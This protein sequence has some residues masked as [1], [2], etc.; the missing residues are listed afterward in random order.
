MKTCWLVFKKDEGNRED[1]STLYCDIVMAEDGKEAIDLIS[2]KNQIAPKRLYAIKKRIH[3]K[4][5]CLST[6]QS[7]SC[8]EESESGDGE[9]NSDFND[10]ESNEDTEEAG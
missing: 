4:K 5:T 9:W 7:E 8:D 2:K 3:T 1:C 6:K 10:Y